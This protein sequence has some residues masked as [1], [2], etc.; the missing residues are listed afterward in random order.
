VIAALFAGLTAAVLGFFNAIVRIVATLTRAA[1]QI[2]TL[3]LKIFI[4]NREPPSAL[5]I[6]P[7]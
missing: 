7:G 6:N 4:S 3:P 2:L 5:G 1:L